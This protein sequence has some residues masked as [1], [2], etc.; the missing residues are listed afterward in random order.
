MND[1]H[2]LYDVQKERETTDAIFE[3]MKESNQPLSHWYYGHFH[4]S[5]H[6]SIDG[7]LF[8]MLD[9]M[10]FTEVI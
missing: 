5:W 9:I 1:E 7:I 6:S 8:K 3:K 2:L 4:Q 10:E